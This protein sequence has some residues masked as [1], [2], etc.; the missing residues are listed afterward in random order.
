MNRALFELFEYS[1]VFMTGG[2][3]YGAIEIGFRG[4]THWTMLVTGGLCLSGFHYI[5]KLLKNKNILV[6]CLAGCVLITFLEF[7]AGCIVNLIFRL[8]VWDYSSQP[9]N[10]LGQICPLF[11]LFWF[12]LCIPAA[13]L[14]KFIEHRFAKQKVEKSI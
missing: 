4:H 7:I 12:L 2:V 8:N 6:K 11:S 13:L 3:L 5:C 1:S 10:L 14:C 9:L